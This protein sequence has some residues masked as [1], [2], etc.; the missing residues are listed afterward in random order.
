MRKDK[1][2]SRRRN[3]RYTA[4]MVRKPNDLHGC[5]LSDISDTGARIDVE[6]ADTVPDH[7]MLWLARN[8][9]ARRACSVVWRQ[10][11]QIGVQFKG[12]LVDGDRASLVP[13][14]APQAGDADR[15][16]DESEVA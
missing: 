13:H 5:A 7:F 16:A 3:I 12:R 9:S 14:V 2:K 11:T 15:A 8:G 1:R 6:D 4:W 10:P